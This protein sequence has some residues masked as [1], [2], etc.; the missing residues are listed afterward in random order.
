MELV[1]II[2]VIA[3]VAAAEVLIFGKYAL[4]GIY[5][6]ASVNKAEVY[7]GETLE[8]T[9]VVENRRFVALPWI[10]TE[11]SAS[12]WLAF[13]RNDSAAQTSGGDNTFI[14]GVFSLKPRSKCTRV[15]KIK[16]M[17]RGVFSFD[18][19]VVTATDMLGL[20]RVSRGFKVGIS[21]TVL[22]VGADGENAVLS[23]NEP[24][25]EILVR[26]FINE[27]PFM[28]AGSREY[29]GREPLNRIN[30]KYTAVTGKLMAMNNEFTTSRNTLILMNMQRK[31]VVPITSADI[32]DTEAFI[33]L[34]VRLMWESIDSGCG[35]AFATNGGNANGTATGFVKTAEQCEGVLRML[36][37]LSD[38]C[39][40]DFGSFLNALN[41]GSFTDVIILTPY[42]DDE[43][44]LFA[45]SLKAVTKRRFSIQRATF[46]KI[47][48]LRYCTQENSHT[49]LM[50]AMRRLRN[51]K[52][53]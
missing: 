29:T 33:K 25:G 40:F 42:I 2:L 46:P 9:E 4:K 37:Q 26:R 23:F 36:A 27:D 22:P 14:P 41:Y 51:E 31:G 8:L 11:L 50:Q 53:F 6:S 28:I 21:I 17:K 32:R 24:V 48:M 43:M 20:V 10:K 35:F 30:W 44:A 12:R 45:K 47:Q 34:S 38:S 49:R 5:Y 18:D 16:C 7:E 19:T 39:S 52:D 13:S 15:R 3:A 1:A